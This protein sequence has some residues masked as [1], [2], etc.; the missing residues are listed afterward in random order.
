[1]IMPEHKMC[2]FTKGERPCLGILCAWFSESGGMCAVSKLP[3]SL[4]V[5]EK[6]AAA[7]HVEA[8]PVKKTRARAVP[9]S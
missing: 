1:M 9:P 3:E 7:E 5:L 4:K 2:P 6:L 8:Q